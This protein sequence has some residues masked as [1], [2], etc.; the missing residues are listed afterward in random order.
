MKLHQLTNRIWY[1][2]ND[3]TTDRPTLGYIMGDRRS[4][5]LDAG[6]SGAHA[7]LFLEAGTGLHFPF[8][9]GSHLWYGI[10]GAACHRFRKN[11]RP[12]AADGMLG[13][14]RKRNGKT[15]GNRRGIRLLRYPYSTGISR[16]EPHSGTGRRHHVPGQTDT[17]I[18]ELSTGIMG[19]DFPSC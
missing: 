4:V 17:G 16:S 5:M 7:E 1:T 13:M 15:A 14:V 11:Q 18:G 6:N 2:E 10:F 9:L 8:S 19:R 3:S 12:A